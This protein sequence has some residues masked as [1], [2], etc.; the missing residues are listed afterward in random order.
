MFYEKWS[1][2]H[3][4]AKKEF[5][6]KKNMITLCFLITKAVSSLHK[7]QLI[8]HFNTNVPFI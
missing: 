3:T 7:L 8:D 5:R 6:N 2:K 4:Y 1:L